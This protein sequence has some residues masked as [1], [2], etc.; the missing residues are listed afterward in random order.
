MPSPGCRAEGGWWHVARGRPAR[1]PAGGPG[2][3]RPLPTYSFPFAGV[4]ERSSNP[5]S[6]I[7]EGGKRIRRTLIPPF[8]LRLVQPGV[9]PVRARLRGW[10][11]EAVPATTGL[12][13][14]SVQPITPQCLW[15]GGAGRC[16]PGP[17]CPAPWWPS[18]EPLALESSSPGP[19]AGEVASAV[20]SGPGSPRAL[21]LVGVFWPHQADPGVPAPTCC[22]RPCICVCTWGGKTCDRWPHAASHLPPLSVKTTSRSR[23]DHADLP[24]SDE[25][26]ESQASQ[27]QAPHVLA[28]ITVNAPQDK[29]WTLLSSAPCS[30]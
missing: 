29:G 10:T 2:P 30:E 28:T 5:V 20:R 8:Q 3:G 24:F 21:L 12:R 17:E 13:K 19:R 9:S 25:E 18:L 26:G 23:P 22:H 1:A 7:D 14:A 4:C 27:V 11:A 15:A 16:S 6:G